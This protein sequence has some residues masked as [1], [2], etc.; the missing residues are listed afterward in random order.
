MDW[1]TTPGHQAAVVCDSI[2]S[3]GAVWRRSVWLDHTGSSDL[4]RAEALRC[5]R[6]Y[7][8]SFARVD[9]SQSSELDRLLASGYADVEVG[10]PHVE[11][12][13]GEEQALIQ[14]RAL[15]FD[16]NAPG[17]VEHFNRM[18]AYHR[19]PDNHAKAG[20]VVEE[21]DDDIDAGCYVD[22]ELVMP[23]RTLGGRNARLTAP[24]QRRELIRRV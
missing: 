2:T 3:T 19:Y 22:S 9:R 6:D 11:V 4:W 10:N 14:K 24:S 13:I 16:S 12:R 5:K 23:K 7:G 1:G 8:A 15:F 20:Q 18:C 21:E 17:M